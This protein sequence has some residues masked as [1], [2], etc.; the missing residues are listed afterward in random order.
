MKMDRSWQISITT[1]VGYAPFDE[2]EVAFAVVV[3]SVG[4]D[5]GDGINSKIGSRILDTYFDI[6]EDHDEEAEDSEEE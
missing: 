2:P 1:L 4:I 5:T 6:K 3:P